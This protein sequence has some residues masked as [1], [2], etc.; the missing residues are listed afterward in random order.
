MRVLANPNDQF[1]SHG[2]PCKPQYNTT[3]LKHGEGLN[4]Q[5]GKAGV[6]E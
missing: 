4:R 2:Y 3:V 6:D 1:R 5:Q